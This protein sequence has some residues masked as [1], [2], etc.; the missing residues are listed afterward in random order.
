MRY[1]RDEPIGT[2]VAYLPVATDTCTDR[3][4]PQDH[5]VVKYMLP[6]LGMI[7]SNDSMHC[8]NKAILPC[9]QRAPQDLGLDQ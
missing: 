3:I 9:N 2:L 1:D 8:C 7:G 5:D 6:L 4:L